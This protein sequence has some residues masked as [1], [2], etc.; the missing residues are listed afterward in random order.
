MSK[1]KFLQPLKFSKRWNYCWKSSKK[2]F[3]TSFQKD[4]HPWGIFSIMMHLFFMLLKILL[5]GRRALEIK[6]LNSSP[7]ISTWVQRVLHGM[8]SSISNCTLEDLHGWSMRVWC[9]VWL[10]DGGEPTNWHW[11]LTD[12]KW[13]L[14]WI[15]DDATLHRV[16]R[17]SLRR[18]KILGSHSLSRRVC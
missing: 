6:A 9:S 5:R 17:R 15:F 1:K 8:P 18:I 11:L 4:Y 16:R 14:H 3:M 12:L 7:T 13:W 10:D 2:L